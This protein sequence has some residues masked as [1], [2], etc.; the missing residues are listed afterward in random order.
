MAKNDEVKS[1][2]REAP[3]PKLKQSRFHQGEAMI[4]TM[5]AVPETGTKYEDLFDPTY[6][7]SVSHLLDIGYMIRVVPEDG[8][9][10]ADLYVA[11]TGIGG[12][13]VKEFYFKAWDEAYEAP[14]SI[15]TQYETNWGGPHHK[16]RVV[17]KADQYVEQAK[18]ANE[19]DAN[20]WLADNADALM[21]GFRKMTEE[22]AA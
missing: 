18:F 12:V 15:L 22:E 5:C 20:R 8:K 9:Y 6:W 4:K 1:E 2:V 17:R 3:K 10:L 14:A 7:T 16:W 19:S 11:S 21:K 13:R